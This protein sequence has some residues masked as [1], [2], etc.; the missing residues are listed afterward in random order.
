MKK[1]PGHSPGRLFPSPPALEREKNGG[2]PLSLPKAFVFIKSLF[3]AFPVR[4]G[5]SFKP[6][7]PPFRQYRHGAGTRPEKPSNAFKENVLCR[8]RTRLYAGLWRVAPAF[9]R[10]CGSVSKHVTSSQAASGGPQ[11]P[12]RLA[13]CQAGESGRAFRLSRTTQRSPDAPSPLS[14]RGVVHAELY[15]RLFREPAVLHRQ[16]HDGA[17]PAD[18]LA[19]RPA[20]LQIRRGHHPLRVHDRRAGHAPPFRLSGGPVP[21]QDT[22]PRLRYPVRR[23]V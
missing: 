9:L 8:R 15:C 18:L 10:P 21:A 13:R 19:R 23:P 5:F 20:R 1:P 2:E 14:Q 17:R 7:F 12:S 11:I 16:L 4:A 22:V 6:F 3:A